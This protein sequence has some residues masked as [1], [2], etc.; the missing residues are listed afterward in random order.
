M[1]PLTAVL[2]AA[3]GFVGGTVNAV[4]GS[5]TL[6]VYP[7]L[8]AAGLPPVTANGTN[9]TGLSWGSLSSAYGY[10]RE[11]TGRMRILAVPLVASFAAACLGAGLVL[12]L[13]ERVFV[14]VVPWLILAATVLVAVQPLV[15]RR[16]RDRA[17]RLGDHSA[18]DGRGGPTLTVAVAGSGV[19]G[20]YFGA[21]QGVILMAVL[22]LLYDADL[23]RSNGAKNLLAAS[24]NIAAALVFALAG[25]VWWLAA[26][27]VA[28]GAIAGGLVGARV[29]R[30]LPPA[31]M[32]AAVVVVGLVA[33]V[34]L[35]VR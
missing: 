33:T 29:A 22:G 14:A 10:R 30:R 12:A 15:V 32:R 34:S 7:A 35:V 28:V 27:I 3:A 26:A 21:A 11:L 24:A 18:P 31:V 8:I 5:G 4:V 13:P 16:L 6:V 9:T 1:E 20:G 19:Y 23:Q 25:R 17:A 2:L